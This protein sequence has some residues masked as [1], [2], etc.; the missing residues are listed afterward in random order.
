MINLLSWLL[1]A[2][3]IILIF[4]S[5]ILAAKFSFISI[6][7]FIKKDAKF[8]DWLVLTISIVYLLLFL[9]MMIFHREYIVMVFSILAIILIIIGTQHQKYED[10]KAGRRWWTK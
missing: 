7:Q 10:R 3:Q 1:S 9:Y 5:I 2:F 4:L 8:K 6:K